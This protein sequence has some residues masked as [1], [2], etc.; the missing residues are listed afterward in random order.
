M[1]K[2]AIQNFP[3]PKAGFFRGGRGRVGGTLTLDVRTS[4]LKILKLTRIRPRE[5]G[6]SISSWSSSMFSLGAFLISA[7]CCFFLFWSKMSNPTKSF[8]YSENSS[9]KLKIY[10]RIP[11]KYDNLYQGME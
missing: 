1:S 6:K 8:W 5:T 3:Y 7:D 4:D 10:S 2:Y 11:S 9:I